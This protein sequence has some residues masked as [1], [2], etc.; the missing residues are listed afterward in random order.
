MVFHSLTAPPASRKHLKSRR[1]LPLQATSR[2]KGACIRN[3]NESPLKA[4]PDHDTD[5]TQLYR[6]DFYNASLMTCR[7]KRI[8]RAM[9]DLSETQLK[10]PR[11]LQEY[12]R[13]HWITRIKPALDV[14]QPGLPNLTKRQR[15]RLITSLTQ[16]CWNAETD[17]FTAS[18]EQRLKGEY[19]DDVAVYGRRLG[20][21][22]SSAVANAESVFCRLEGNL[23]IDDF[24]QCMGA[25]RSCY[26]HV[27]RCVGKA[28]RWNCY[29]GRMYSSRSL[30]C[31]YITGQS[32][33]RQR[34]PCR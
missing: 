15:L 32:I 22:E 28:C 34:E 11:A 18:F 33:A 16:R 13:E 10:K 3:P 31:K 6:I 7:M 30:R 4:W 1:S 24:L 14:V 8:L 23:I 26:L 2:R 5:F 27:R 17:E 19:E 29:R 20:Y 21:S 25:V 12:S 9:A